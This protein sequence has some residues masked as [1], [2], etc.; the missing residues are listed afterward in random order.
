MQIK[1]HKYTRSDQLQYRCLEG[2]YLLNLLEN[3]FG[4][5]R[6][7]RNI[8]LALDVKG[9]EAEWTLG[10]ALAE[11]SL[12]IEQFI[13]ENNPSLDVLDM[14]H[15]FHQVVASLG[16]SL[17]R[18]L[19]SIATTLYRV[20]TSPVRFTH[21]LFQNKYK[22]KYA[23]L[24][25]IIKNNQVKLDRLADLEEAHA[26]LNSQVAALTDEKKELQRKSEDSESAKQQLQ[27][28]LQAIED[29][30]ARSKAAVAATQAEMKNQV[31]KLEN[32]IKICSDSKSSADATISELT[33]KLA[34]CEQGAVDS[35]GVQDAL[36]ICNNDAAASQTLLK[37]CQESQISNGNLKDSLEKCTKDTLASQS[38]HA[39]AMID[40]ERKL[41]KLKDA[42]KEEIKKLESELK[43]CNEK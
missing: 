7:S 30:K 39:A 18:G 40:V 23:V 38:S 43:V 9:H 8:T 25:E 12:P 22:S 33:N 36:N 15:Q 42:H 11:I 27:I 28:A 31:E 5:N 17:L 29:E 10:F 37:T 41:L 6:N 21:E 24:Q 2:V 3:G 35:K 14:E 26:E 13:R 1:K 32:N 34:V 19:T 4:F 16:A 20:H